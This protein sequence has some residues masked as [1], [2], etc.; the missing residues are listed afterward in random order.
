ML[1]VIVSAYN[2]DKYI[3]K[4]LRT[5]CGQ[6]Y[7]DIEI[8]VVDDGSTD[9]TLRICKEYES[10]DCRVKVL[11]QNNQGIICTRNNGV[12]NAQGDYVT[13]VDGDDWLEQDT[14]ANMINYISEDIDLVTAGTFVD[15]KDHTVSCFDYFRE[16][17]F[18]KN[19]WIS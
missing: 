9:A 14:Y 12:R 4:C 19:Y 7:T 18:E 2:V 3:G 11:H 10:M 8:I 6:S 13:F 16:G 5:V 1:T 17:L 15:Y